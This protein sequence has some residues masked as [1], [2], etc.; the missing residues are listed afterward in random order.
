MKPLVEF[1]SLIGR[2]YSALAL[3]VFFFVLFTI[4][5]PNIFLTQTT[6]RLVLADRTVIA[7]IAIGAIVPFA[8]G[9]F[10]VSVGAILGF[11]F[12]AATWLV[13]HTAIPEPLIMIIVPLL[14]ALLGAINGAIVVKLGVDSFIGTLATSQILSAFSL[15]LSEN[16]QVIGNFSPGFRNMMIHQFLG[17]TLDV[18]LMLLIAI[19][20]WFVLEHM[21]IGRFVFA[22]GGNPQAARLSGVRVNRVVWGSL[23][24]SAFMAGVGA[25]VVASKVGVYANTYGT[26]QLFPAFAAVFFGAT[27]VKG[28]LN[29]WGTLIA[30]YALA[31]GEAGLSLMGS[32]ITWWV[33]PLFNG[34]AL[35]GAVAFAAQQLRRRRAGRNA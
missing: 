10:D 18:W 31:F 20:F 17:I 26:A 13:N 3:L 24:V 2:R 22:T 33:T 23:I 15:L 7:I 21:P 14:C 30:L 12:I 28:R 34:L 4:L 8:A 32:N 11:G 9:V 25:I 35:L 5:L 1:I 19:I 16:R 6:M 27:Q 29:V